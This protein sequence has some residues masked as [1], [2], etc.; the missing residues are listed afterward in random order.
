M[1]RKISIFI[2]LSLILSFAACSGGEGNGKT[3]TPSDTTVPAVTTSPI[4]YEEDDLPNTLDFGG[5]KVVILAPEGETW[6]KEI[7]VEEL[8]S[9]PVNDSIYNRERFVEDRLGV[10]IETEY[11]LADDYNNKVTVQMSSYEDTHQIYAA[12]TVYFAQNVFDNYLMDLYDVEHLDLEKPWWSQNFTDA[13]EVKG[14]LYLATGS[15][16]LSVTRLL[17]AVYYNKTVA[18][19]YEETIPELGDLYTLVDSGKWTFDKLTELS[20]GIYEDVNGNSGR[21][22]EDTYGLLMNSGITVDPI[23]SSFDINIFSRTDDGWFELDVNTDKLYSALDK[24]VDLLHNSSGTSI[25][26]SYGDTSL[27]M[28]SQ[29]FASDSAL[30]MVNRLLEAENA[31]LRNMKSDYGIL[32]FPKYDEQQNDYYSFPHDQYLSFSIPMTNQNP[33][34]AGAVLEAMASYS[35]RDTLPTYLDQV[36]KGKYMSDAQSRK[37]IDLVVKG[38]KVDS[39]WIYAMTLGQ[40]GQSFRTLMTEGDTSYATTYAGAERNIKIALKYTGRDFEPN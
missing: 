31:V 11:V 7:S 35:Y 34:V 13:A 8:A 22:S 37:M 6:E 32:P 5:Q 1:K 21:D 4:V 18:E 30:F 38:F 24:M 17:F 2:V 36:L 29:Y 14:S 20:A 12:R 23:W 15:Y 39:S 3:T 26:E 27:R 33:D 9:E 28:M 10:E 25:V 16:A 40:F 19:N